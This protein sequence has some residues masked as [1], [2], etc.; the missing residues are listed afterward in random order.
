MKV[1]SSYRAAVLNEKTIKYHV[2]KEVGRFAQMRLKFMLEERQEL[3][4]DLLESGRLYLYLNRFEREVQSLIRQQ[5]EKMMRTD[6]E[7]RTA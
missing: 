5:E 4:K 6:K 2:S 1:N 3:L 7:Y